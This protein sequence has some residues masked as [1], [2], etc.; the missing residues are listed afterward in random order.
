MIRPA[1]LHWA[2]QP[3]SLT[4]VYTCPIILTAPIS[5]CTLPCSLS[6]ALLHPA[7]VGWLRDA[8][9]EEMSD[10][11]GL[12]MRLVQPRGSGPAQFGAGESDGAEGGKGGAW[13]G[14]EGR[15]RCATSGLI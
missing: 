12:V 3:H 7:Q 5:S 10:R 8:R 14:E 4:S 15:S 13:G 1:Y 11:A 2:L 9:C 6:R